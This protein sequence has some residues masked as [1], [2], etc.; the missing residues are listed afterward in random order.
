MSGGRR[1][2]GRRILG[3]AVC[4]LPPAL[5]VASLIAGLAGGS[6]PWFTG[7]TFVIAAATIGLTN[8]FLSFVR[9][10]LRSASRRHI[11]GIPVVGSALVV[12]G[13]LYGFGA[14][15]TALLAL[16][17]SAIDTGGAPWFAISTWRDRSLW[18]D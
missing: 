2:I 4:A 3:V 17:A 11:S 16:A 13:V 14:L 12:I 5:S 15:G 8:A 6:A 9:P 10:R 18:D 7:I 1:H